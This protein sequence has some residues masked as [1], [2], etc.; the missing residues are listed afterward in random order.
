M[1]F[2]FP[3]RLISHQLVNELL[4]ENTV[5]I[6]LIES[7]LPLSYSLF[8]NDALI[9]KKIKSKQIQILENNIPILNFKYNDFPSIG[10]W[11]KVNA[12][13]ICLE[14]WLGFSDNIDADGEINNKK[15]IINLAVNETF[16][17]SFLLNFNC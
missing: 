13:F 4:S 16:E 7:C 1:R 9:F 8:K 6:G 17:A 11:T 2:E 5:E 15:G 10:I 3:E 12:P 14:P